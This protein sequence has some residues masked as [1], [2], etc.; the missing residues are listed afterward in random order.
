MKKTTAVALVLLLTIVLLVLAWR[1]CRAPAPGIG[2]ATGG[3]GTELETPTATG[4]SAE[5]GGCDG[6]PAPPPLPT[7]FA[8]AAP[9]LAGV[10]R[11]LDAALDDRQKAWLRCFTLDDELLARTHQGLGRW[12]RATL[13]LSRPGP[14]VAA[15]G[16]RSPDEA[17][18]LIILAYAHHLRGRELS[19]AEAR[20][21]R[22]EALA[23]VAVTR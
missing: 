21:R 18:S 1:A 20:A 19:P 2:P 9:N 17:S 23:D 22:A 7:T 4:V 15:L 10:V 6:Q 3:P 13:H 11:A 12:L 5:P 16:A 8:P 14:L